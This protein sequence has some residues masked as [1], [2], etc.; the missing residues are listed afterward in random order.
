M[1]VLASIS[2]APSA[3]IVAWGLLLL[4]GLILW[5][6]GRR[7]LM[8]VTAT[9]ALIAGGM[10]G[11]K[12]G[13]RW[14]FGVPAWAWASLTAMLVMCFALLAFR[15]VVALGMA[16]VFALAAPLAV[17]GGAELSGRTE[18]PTESLASVLGGGSEPGD[19]TM[20]EAEPTAPPADDFDMWWVQ[21]D[22]IEVRR[23]LDKLV[24][25]DLVGKR[26]NAALD[27]YYAGSSNGH[28]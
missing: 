6:A 25:L 20:V 27:L 10:I 22:P 14:D 5:A 8:P 3:A 19:T 12:M 18:G 26:S 17:W 13:L 1:N 4:S 9:L 2:V 16:A 11:W 24:D 21:D 7:V 23:V 28:Q 15:A